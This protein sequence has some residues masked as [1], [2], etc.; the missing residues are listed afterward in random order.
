MQKK[1]KNI[2][3]KK[4]EQINALMLFW[5]FLGAFG[6]M[7]CCGCA[8][9]C[10]LKCGQ[11]PE[12]K[13]GSAEINSAKVDVGYTSVP[14]CGG[15]FTSGWGCGSCLWGEKIVF[16]SVKG[17]YADNET[18]MIGCGDVYY[19][20][21]CGGSGTSEENFYVGISVPNS[22]VGA[23]YCG[24]TMSRPLRG[25][26]HYVCG[27]TQDGLTCGED[28]NETFASFVSDIEEAADYLEDSNIQESSEAK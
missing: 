24:D 16:A 26:C 25:S 11:K 23:V 2:N 14:A 8:N 27:K 17:E 1:D 7:M 10:H 12:H 3:R 21:S 5:I 4:K 28:D 22:G 13:S 19:G 6:F 9:G 20:N 15:C 18:Q